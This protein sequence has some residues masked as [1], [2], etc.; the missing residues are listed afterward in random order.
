MIKYKAARLQCL[1][2]IDILISFTKDSLVSSDPVSLTL[3][4]ISRP[5]LTTPW[6]STWFMKKC[7]SGLKRVGKQIAKKGMFTFSE[8]EINPY[9][10]C[11]R[12]WTS[13]R[14]SGPAPLP[15][16]SS[17][18]RTRSKKRTEMMAQSVFPVWYFFLLTPSKLSSFLTCWATNLIALMARSMAGLKGAAG[19]V[20]SGTLSRKE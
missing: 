19:S 17:R 14:V 16:I 7:I 12:R 15:R 9:R 20:S 4:P 2:R 1:I 5:F 18:P 8:W 3:F 10:R 6:M 11:M 13:T